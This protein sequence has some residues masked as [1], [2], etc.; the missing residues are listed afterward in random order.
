[1]ANRYRVLRPFNGP[2]SKRLAAGEEVDITGWRNA[3]RLIEQGRLLAVTGPEPAPPV[4]PV[5]RKEPRHA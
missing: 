3:P 5:Q 4:A 2:G 1:M